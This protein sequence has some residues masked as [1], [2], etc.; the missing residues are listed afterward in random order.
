MSYLYLNYVARCGTSVPSLHT[1]A[2]GGGGV[3]GPLGGFSP[4]ASSACTPVVVLLNWSEFLLPPSA[5]TSALRVFD[6]LN[7]GAHIAWNGSNGVF[8]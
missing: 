7:K 2:R 1:S 5:M 3:G 8:L 4:A 6:C